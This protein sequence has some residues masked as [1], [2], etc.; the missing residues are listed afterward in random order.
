MKTLKQILGEETFQEMVLPSPDFLNSPLTRAGSMT[1]AVISNTGETAVFGVPKYE[2][3]FEKD[4]YYAAGRERNGHL[5]GQSPA[6]YG[7]N[8]GG[9]K[10]VSLSRHR[11]GEETDG[12]KFVK[13]MNIFKKAAKKKDPKK[14]STHPLETDK[15]RNDRI[16]GGK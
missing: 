7:Q 10:P 9:N 4:R 13:N 3:V 2:P 8:N 12:D 6:V 14:P 15:N 1:K 5:E 11:I 16:R